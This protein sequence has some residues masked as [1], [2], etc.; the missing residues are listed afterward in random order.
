LISSEIVPKMQKI[1]ET[2]TL[3]K[4]NI[5]YIGSRKISS[6]TNSITMI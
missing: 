3:L 5:H 4:V 2:I 1:S 6:L